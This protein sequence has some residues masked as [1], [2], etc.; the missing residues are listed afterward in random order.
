MVDDS[1]QLEITDNAGGI[2]AE[3]LDRIFEPFYT[4]KVQIARPGLGLAVAWR[5][6][7]GLG[8]EIHGKNVDGGICFSIRLPLVVAPPT[9]GR[10]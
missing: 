10:Q 2:D 7:D 3:A 1:Y 4:T 6:V 5:L 9:S 8:G